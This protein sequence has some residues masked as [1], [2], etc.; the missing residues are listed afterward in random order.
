MV[1]DP[2]PVAAALWWV[3]TGA[4]VWAIKADTGSSRQTSNGYFMDV[5][6]YSPCNGVVASA[7]VV[8]DF[9]KI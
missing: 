9:C 5:Y 2:D 6:I 4:K 7:G 1:Y 8:M 3:H